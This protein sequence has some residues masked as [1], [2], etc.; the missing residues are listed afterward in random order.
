MSFRY[1]S[2]SESFYERFSDNTKRAKNYHDA[3]NMTESEHI[4]EFGKARYS[5]YDSFRVIKSIQN[6]KR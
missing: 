1:K 4:K 3:Y 5:S 6:K 2:T